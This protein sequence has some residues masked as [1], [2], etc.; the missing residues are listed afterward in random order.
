MVVWTVDRAGS[1]SPRIGEHARACRNVI[2]FPAGMVL[3]KS[4]HAFAACDPFSKRPADRDRAG[5]NAMERAG[6]ACPLA[7][8]PEH[9]LPTQAARILHGAAGHL[10]ALQEDRRRP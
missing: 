3:L 10:S 4:K 2:R 9:L 7:A 8:G 5:R 1:V 6:S